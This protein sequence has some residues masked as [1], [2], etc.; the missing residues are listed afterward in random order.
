MSRLTL[1]RCKSW[2]SHGVTGLAI[3]LIPLSKWNLKT[4]PFFSNSACLKPT[5]QI[6][7]ENY[8][9][10][11]IWSTASSETCWIGVLESI[12]HDFMRSH[13]ITDGFAVWHTLQ[14][15][16]D[17]S[18]SD[19]GECNRC[20]RR[21]EGSLPCHLLGSQ[22]PPQLSQQIKEFVHYGLL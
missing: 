17:C 19:V 9:S 14:N 15:F 4:I 2:N 22:I 8:K 6:P 16:S 5:L 7:M 10:N 21:W 13:L 11:A 12:S 3:T 18:T 1:Y 20:N